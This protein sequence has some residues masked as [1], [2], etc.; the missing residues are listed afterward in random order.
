MEY[1]LSLRARRNMSFPMKYTKTAHR[2]KFNNKIEVKAL[3]ERRIN[4][5]VDNFR[6]IS[7]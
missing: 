4:Y 3:S 7:R 5:Q 1:R 2:Y 6:S